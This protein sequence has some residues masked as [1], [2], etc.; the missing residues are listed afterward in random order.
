MLAHKSRWC[1][2]WCAWKYL[3]RVRRLIHRGW[4]EGMRYIVLTAPGG[5][6]D[7]DEWNRGSRVRVK[8]FMRLLRQETGLRCSYFLTWELQRRGALHANLLVAMPYFSEKRLKALAVRAGWGRLASI[9]Q[10]DKKHVRYVSKMGPGGLVGYVTKDVSERHLLGHAYSYSRDWL[11]VAERD[12]TPGRPGCW[13]FSS[14][15]VDVRTAMESAG[16]LTPPAWS[17][18]SLPPPDYV[19]WAEDEVSG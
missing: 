11:V 17:A 15:D 14:S 9:G 6:L 10:A 7:I 2:E 19:G 1:C 8:A 18:Q 16:Y 3:R 13:R 5:D 12:R 4:R